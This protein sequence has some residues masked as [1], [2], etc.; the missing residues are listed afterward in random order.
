MRGGEGERG[1]GGG[2]KRGREEARL[3]GRG[4]GREGRRAIVTPCYE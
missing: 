3:K 2:R 1:E 4:S